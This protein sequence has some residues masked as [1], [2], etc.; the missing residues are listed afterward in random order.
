MKFGFY[1]SKNATRLVGA[2]QANILQKKNTAFVLTDYSETPHLQ[3]ACDK[4]EIPLYNYSYE[5]YSLSGKDRNKFISD[6]FLELLRK[7]ECDYGFAWGGRLLLV[8]D[9]LEEYEKRL[10]NFHPSLLP[11]YKGQT[12][13]IDAALQEN[14]LLLGNTAHFI[15]EKADDGT[16]IMQSIFCSHNFKSYDDVLDLQI[17]M[18]KQIILW[19][20]QKR[21]VF[22]NDKF[23]IINA[24]YE[25]D[26]FIPNLEFQSLHQYDT[27]QTTCP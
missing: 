18:L 10:I 16:M 4:F 20:E 27:S 12:K 7:N 11:A 1:V 6:R 8:G 2:L 23:R 25:I 26:T 14:V 21:F 9:I 15:N 3:Q 5:R 17:L 13:A 19:I 22:D 24:K